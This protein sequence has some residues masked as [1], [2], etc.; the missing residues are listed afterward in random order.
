[1]HQF[2]KGD[3]VVFKGSRGSLFR[4]GEK[5]TILRFSPADPNA[6]YVRTD[7]GLVFWFE[8]A[9]LELDDAPDPV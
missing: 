2:K 9:D 4:A 5:G 6:V 1:M 8:P 3:R 7:R